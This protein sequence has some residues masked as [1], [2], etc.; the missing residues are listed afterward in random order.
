MKSRSPGFTYPSRRAS[1][2]RAVSVPAVAS[3]R[4]SVARSRRSPATS[5]LRCTSVRCVPT[6]VFSG[7]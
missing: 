5:A 6:Y 4:S 3:F 1:P 7:R 2:M